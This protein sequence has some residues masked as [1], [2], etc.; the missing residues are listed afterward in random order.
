MED[1]RTKRILLSPTGPQLDALDAVRGTIP[2]ATYV[3]NVLDKHLRE[4]EA[5]GE[6]VPRG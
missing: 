2:R 3:L 5:K 4:Q 6:R 1:P